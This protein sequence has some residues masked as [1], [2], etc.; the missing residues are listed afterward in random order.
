MVTSIWP[1][2][3]KI[4][5][6]LHIVGRREN[7]LHELQTVFQLLEFGDEIQFELNE[8]D[9]I[10][11][12]GN[13]NGV[14]QADDL[15]Y[16]AATLLRETTGIK[17][18]INISVTK[19]IPMGGGLGGGSSDAA[20]TLVALNQIWGTGLSTLELADMGIN[21]GADVP[22]F[23]HGHSAWGEGIGEILEPLTLSEDWFVVIHP[24][25][26]VN[27]GTIFNNSYLT[28]NT[29]PITI[30]DFKEDDCHNDCESVVFREF[31]EVAEAAQWLGQW[32]KTKL[33]GTGACVFGRFKSRQLANQVFGQIPSKW[34]GFV[35][36]GVNKSPLLDKH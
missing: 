14:K 36:K 8:K 12:T 30:R 34:Q 9:G 35:S 1:A 10:N 28:R 31:P 19:R 5:L 20:T 7:G 27:T 15:I 29:S 24:G 3:A 26:H 6:F 16:K 18:G 2:P 11:L 33:T 22:V 25:C 4:N 13:Y 21:L 23:I 17:Q 32:T